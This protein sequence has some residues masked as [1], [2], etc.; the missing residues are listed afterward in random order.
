[1]GHYVV[2]ICL[3][4]FLFNIIF[5]KGLIPESWSYGTIKPIFK[6]E[7]DPNLAENNRTITILSCFG[8]LF[9]QIRNDRLKEFSENFNLIEGCQAGFRRHF[10]N[11][12]IINSLVNIAK[13]SKISYTV[14]L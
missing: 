14:V 11:L 6:G 1:M 12:F 8:K 9:T 7:G 5:N 13:A 3:R 4:Y 2:Y 10:S